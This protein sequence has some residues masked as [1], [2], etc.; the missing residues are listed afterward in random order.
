MLSNEILPLAVAAHRRLLTDQR[1]PAGT[2][3]QGVTFSYTNDQT[4]MW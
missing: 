4:L 1:T 3:V 2:L